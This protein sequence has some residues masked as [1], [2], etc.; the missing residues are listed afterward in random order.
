MF[1][2]YGKWGIIL[3][4]VNDF[5]KDLI[6]QQSVVGATIQGTGTDEVLSGNPDEKNTFVYNSGNV[7]ISNYESWENVVF[8]GTYENWAVDGNDF[9]LN[10]TE[11]S[12]RISDAKGKLMEFVNGNGKVLMHVCMQKGDDT[13]NGTTYHE[14]LVVIGANDGDN[15]IYAG[16]AGSILWGGGGNDTL[17]GGAGTDNFIYNYGEGND[18]I[19]ADKQDV[20]NLGSVTFE[21][22]RGFKIED[23]RALFVFDDFS[24]LSVMGHAST[25]I[26]EGQAYNADY[27][28]GRLQ[29]ISND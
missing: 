8:N 28:N 5:L 22:I 20:I 9:V 4:N 2:H 16:G 18:V 7:T 23:N 6:N 27:D 3:N 17:I 12:V 1:R 14:P 19:F 15:Y 21:Q 10:A 24:N 13:F 25:F 26:I 29:A 11:G